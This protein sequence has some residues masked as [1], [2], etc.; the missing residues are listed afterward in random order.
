[1]L[2]NA[3]VD[4]RD[5]VAEMAL[6]LPD[7]LLLLVLERVASAED[8]AS[9]SGVCTSWRACASTERLWEA[10]TGA[11]V[12]HLTRQ[13]LP[14][15]RT[16]RE[17]YVELVTSSSISF[18]VLGGRIGDRIGRGRR[19]QVK[20]KVWKDTPQMAVE[21]RGPALVRDEDGCLYALGGACGVPL[22]SV[23]RLPPSSGS[24]QGESE[25]AGWEMVPPMRTARCAA[26]ASHDGHGRIIVSGGGESMYRHAR[27]FASCEAFSA[28]AWL[29]YPA[30]QTP[31]CAHSLTLGHAQAAAASSLYAVAGYDGN[32]DRYLDTIE[33]IDVDAPERGWRIVG[34]LP[35]PRAFAAACVGP[36][37]ALYVLGG[38]DNGSSNFA[39]CVRCAA[40]GSACIRDLRGPTHLLESH[41]LVVLTRHL[42][43][44]PPLYARVALSSRRWDPRSGSTH[45]L[46]PM[47]S[48]RHAFAA[49]F[50]PD[51]LL[52]VA[53]GFE[54]MGTLTSAEC[55]DPRADRWRELP[56]LG[57]GLEFC[58]GAVVW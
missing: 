9:A 23:E 58:S 32:E 40:R 5:A 18:I 10:L 8:L 35:E 4:K 45:A 28:G 33:A 47:T 7:E 26:A 53:G 57:A 24:A 11:E 13:Q 20:D 43:P 22:R 15:G 19:F 48:R 46:A 56:S 49:A 1:M 39:T 38:T 6:L 12:G 30:M 27:V 34:Q 50:A 16:W 31:R 36:Q 44:C 14:L 52:Y 2:T 42:L 37:H 3:C 41:R 55:Y 21:R 54:W 29:P 25:E 17:Y 51:G